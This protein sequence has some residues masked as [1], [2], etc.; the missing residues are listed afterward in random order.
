MANQANQVNR[1]NNLSNPAMVSGNA[2]EQSHGASAAQK[3]EPQVVKP[4][5]MRPRAASSSVASDALEARRTVQETMAQQASNQAR[6]RGLKNKAWKESLDSVV[7]LISNTYTTSVDDR[8]SSSAETP[9]SS[10]ARE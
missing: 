5:L 3:V 4:Q 1:A 6:M 8:R 2:T 10:A 9:D 7:N